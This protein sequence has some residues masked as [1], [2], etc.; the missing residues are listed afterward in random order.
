MSK[1]EIHCA[2]IS[3]EVTKANGGQITFGEYDVAMMQRSCFAPINWIAG[4]GTGRLKQN[5]NKMCAFA[6]VKLGLLKQTEIGYSL[7]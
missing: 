5:Q 4:W 2:E 6:A 7:A 1:S 3:V